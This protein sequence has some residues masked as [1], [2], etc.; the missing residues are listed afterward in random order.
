M[1]T[2][3]NVVV[4][5]DNKVTTIWDF[6][7]ESATYQPV[8]NA[9]STFVKAHAVTDVFVT[10]YKKRGTLKNYEKMAD[11]TVKEWN[12]FFLE[13]PDRFVNQTSRSL[14]DIRG[15]FKE[16][17]EMFQNALENITEEAL[18]VVMELIDSN[19]LYKGAEWRRQVAEILKHKKAYDKLLT[20]EQKELY[21]WEQSVKLDGAV[22]KIKNTSVGTLLVNVSKGM[23]LDIAVRKYEQIVAPNNYK[24]SK[25]IY[26]VKMLQE[27]QKKLEVL[28]YME[29]LE[30]RYARLDDIT[31]NNILFSNRDA[32]KRIGGVSDVF[33]EMIKETVSNPKKFSKVEELAIDKFISDVLPTAKE[34]ELYLENRH[35]GNMVSLIAP[36][37]KGSKSMFKWNNNFSWAYAGNMA[38]SMK[39]RVKEAGGKVDGDLRFSIQWNEN[40]KDNSDLDAHCKEANGNEIYFGNCRKPNFSRLGG[41]LDVDIIHPGGKIAVENIT[42]ADRRKMK[43]GVYK[44][45]VHQYFG[46]IGSF[47]AEIEFDGQIYSYEYNLPVRCGK[48]VQIAEVTLDCNGNFSIKEFLSSNV[49]SR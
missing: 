25:P 40:G 18:L 17:K 30:H 12:H 27:A 35:A 9:L 46:S 36:V 6:D 34:V 47:K 48:I 37:N 33:G 10:D 29:S 39:E 7:A 21:A 14:E 38:D 11:G 44:F 8:I 49:A 41:Q 42:W 23:D 13:L 20:E 32:A 19:T 16:S 28:G 3:G 43:P 24:R 4:I 1:K 31:V 45:F 5:R 26:T 22:T 2:T 15:K